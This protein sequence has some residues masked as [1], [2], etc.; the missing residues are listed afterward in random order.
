MDRP[1][2]SRKACPPRAAQ[3]SAT[4]ARRGAAQLLFCRDTTVRQADEQ[5]SSRRLRVGGN[6]E[7]QPTASVMLTTNLQAPSPRAAALIASCGLPTRSRCSA[8]GHSQDD[9]RPSFSQHQTTSCAADR[10]PPTSTATPLPRLWANEP[11]AKSQPFCPLTR[12]PSIAVTQDDM[13]TTARCATPA[14][15]APRFT[16]ACLPTDF[17]CN[18]FVCEPQRTSASATC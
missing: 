16:A 17:A 2:G 14:A 8:V 13:P 1:R 7:H 9:S 18:V 5:R 6:P 11:I 4:A 10:P 15:C 3:R 12:R